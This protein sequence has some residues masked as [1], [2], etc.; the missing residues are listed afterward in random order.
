LGWPSR[1]AELEKFY[2]TTVLVT[3]Y[4]ILF[5]WV[6]RMMMFG[7]FVGDDAA[8]TL[9]GRRGPQVPFT[10]VLLH[11]LIRDEF[12]RK[13][14][15]SKGNGVDPLDWVETFGA[16]ALRFTLARG[17]SPGGDLTLGEDHVRAARNFATKLFNATRFALLNGAAVGPGETLPAHDELTDADRWILGRLEEVRAEVDSAFD[18]YE[19]SRACESLYHFTWDEFCDWYVELAKTQL[20]EG[21][22]HTTAV[23]AGVLDT[24]LRLLH[25]VIPFITEALWQAV[26][27]RESLVIADWPR[28]SGVSVDPV[29]AQ[30]I[31]D[32]QKLVTEVRRFRSDQ[33]L[34]DR[35]KVPARLS[36][37]DAADLSTQVGAITSLA[38]LTAPGPEFTPSVSLEVGLGPGPKGLKS[39]VVVDLDTSGTIDV[40]AERRRLEKDLAAAE[41]ELA[42]TTAK[43]GNADF[44]AKAPAAVV[45]KQRE[46]QRVAREETDR[47]TARLAGLQ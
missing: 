22:S 16:D 18:G 45:D 47:I 23:L 13:M 38:W 46:R 19:F 39:L 43:L 6:A 3:G 40:G 25:P 34:A 1:T 4:D 26:T 35:Q 31:T 8:I 24:L 12:G 7:A 10:N 27:R 44:M 14:S 36:G 33:G 20:A 42:S 28:L 21:L 37:I 9:D 41:K 32:M 11:G 2:P 29:A 5:F 15:K 30:R 17:A